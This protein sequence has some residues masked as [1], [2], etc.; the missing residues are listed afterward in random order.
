M[1][2]EA[3]HGGRLDRRGLDRDNGS[4]LPGPAGGLV[5]LAFRFRL[6]LGGLA[7][8]GGF[9]RLLGLNLRQTFGLKVVRRQRGG[10]SIYSV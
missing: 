9:T 5:V 3:V 2:P 7:L 8:L 10:G 1:V 6:R 4:R